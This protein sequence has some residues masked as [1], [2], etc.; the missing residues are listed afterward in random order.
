M[1]C[2]MSL[3]NKFE[4]WFVTRPQIRDTSNKFVH[5]TEN[6]VLLGAAC[7]ARSALGALHAAQLSARHAVQFATLAS[8]R[9]PPAPARKLSRRA[10]V[11]PGGPFAQHGSCTGRAAP[12][13]GARRLATAQA[14]ARGRRCGQ[15]RGAG[16]GR[17]HTVGPSGTQLVTNVGVGPPLSK[18]SSKTCGGRCARRLSRPQLAKV[19]QT[20]RGRHVHRQLPQGSLGVFATYR[21]ATAS[22]TCF[23]AGSFA[24]AH[25]A[26]AHNDRFAIH[27]TA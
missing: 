14:T 5:G 12:P 25:S 3:K 13:I 16:G 6:T 19:G 8:P 18:V 27:A 20:R 4:N 21:H 17:C 7:S 23:T 24:A 22:Q 2:K 26:H 11:R 1:S 15:C 9:P 10:P